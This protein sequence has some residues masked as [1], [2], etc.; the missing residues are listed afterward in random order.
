MKLVRFLMNVH[1]IKQ[2]VICFIGK[3]LHDDESDN[4]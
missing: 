4:D 2:P 3:C 1:D